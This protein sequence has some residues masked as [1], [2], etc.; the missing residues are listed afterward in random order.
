MTTNYC[1]GCGV[2]C[3]KETCMACYKTL[4]ASV[5]GIEGTPSVAPEMSAAGL[6]WLARDLV[7]MPSGADVVARYVRALMFA[8]EAEQYWRKRYEDKQL[9]FRVVAVILFAVVV[10]VIVYSIVRLIG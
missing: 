10:T 2:L 7:R 8:N 4:S 5:D 3:E 6:D 9:D 1:L